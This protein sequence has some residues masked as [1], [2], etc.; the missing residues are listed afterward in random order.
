MGSVYSPPDS[1]VVDRIQRA[2]PSDELR[3]RARATNLVERE[4]KFDIV[5][6]FYT[7][8]FGFAA[9]SDRSLQAFLERYVE[10]ADCDDLSY[11]AFHDWFEPGFVAL[12]REILDDAIENLDTGRADLSGR[13]E[14]FRDVLIA[15]A[16]IV[17]LYQD[18]ADVYAAT[19]EDQAEL[20][21]HLIESLSTGLPTRFRTTDGTTHE[22]SQLPTGEWV[23]DALILLDL[24]FYD[25][26]LFDRIDQNGGWFVSRVKDNANF[27]IVEELRTWRGNSIPLEGESL[28]AV[29]DDLQRQEI[30]V[31]ITLSFERKRGSGAS[32]TRTFR[33]VG[34]RNEETEEYHLYLTNLGNDDYSAPDIA[35][36]YRARWEVEL[37][38]KELKSRFGLDEIN[39]TD[40]YIIEAL[41]IMAA[42]SLMMS[43][44]IV[45]ELRSLEARQREVEAA[46]DAD[47][48]ASRLPRRRC[49][50]AVE[51]H[52]HLIQLYLMVE[53]GY[54]L[55]D[56][57]EL[58][59]WASRNPNPHRDRLREQVERGEFG[60]GRH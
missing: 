45:D 41:I 51:R 17:S 34:L 59:L 3:E 2:F 22:R 47:E 54:E 23:A 32:A 24:G 36:L 37:L 30:D 42:I 1:V 29:L 60:F 26:W 11:A 27:E 5:A 19:G 38:F 15:D 52:A 35:Q 44:V 28:Q 43:R 50:L 14:R 21:L 49:S 16:T 4:R 20:K 39:T 57:D 40:A 18:A 7:L 25:F 12:L 46:A 9:G 13:L 10:M 31:R 58:L 6:L 56:L 8:S 33:L 55:P 53:L 48:S